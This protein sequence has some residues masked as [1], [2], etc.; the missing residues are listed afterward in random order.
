MA[1]D[2]RTA[3]GAKRTGPSA[4]RRRPGSGQRGRPGGAESRA[5]ILETAGRLFAE[6][7]FNGVS[8]RELARAAEVNVSAIAYYFRGK[9][10]LYHAVLRQL[11][12][13]T[14]PIFAPVVARLVAEVE[15]AAGDRYALTRVAAW[16]VDGVLRA[17]LS[18]ERMSWQMGLMLREFH[19]PSRE[20]G[21]LLRDR[22]HPMHDAVA[23]LVA[24]ATGVRPQAPETL[25][26]TICVIGQC[27]SFG[28]LRNLVCAR[29][30]WS[31]YGAE[32]VERIV[33]TVTR[34]VLAMLDLPDAGSKDGTGAE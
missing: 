22:I 25:L 26:L 13:D 16:F 3:V 1:A 21:M 20:F 17:I 6:R 32:E 14:E 10:G 28:A 23:R 11:I 29:L 5:R 8:T 2:K 7:G 18:N 24:A 31:G 33:D 19:Q 9:K 34:A 4:A 30:G 12:E 27:M 15:R